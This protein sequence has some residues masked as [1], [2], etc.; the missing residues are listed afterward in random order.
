MF[1]TAIKNK[2]GVY[3]FITQ[4]YIVGTYLAIYKDG[5]YNQV[6]V[7]QMCL[8]KEEMNFHRTL[9]RRAI[10]NGDEILEESEEIPKKQ[11][12]TKK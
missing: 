12:T 11:R 9:R 10:K 7:A 3:R 1:V 6:P 5:D 2:D 8:K 4:Q